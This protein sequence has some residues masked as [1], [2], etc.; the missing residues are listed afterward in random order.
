MA[1]RKITAA[2]IKLFKPQTGGGVEDVGEVF[3]SRIPVR[4]QDD[5]RGILK[6]ILDLQQAKEVSEDIQQHQSDSHGMAAGYMW[7]R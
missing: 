3:F 1:T 7:Q 2:Q 6:N 4:S 5:Y